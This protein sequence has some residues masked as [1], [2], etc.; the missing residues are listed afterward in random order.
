MKTSVKI[1]KTVNKKRLWKSLL[2]LS[3][4]A[5]SILPSFSQDLGSYDLKVDGDFQDSILANTPDW[6]GNP[7]YDSNRF[8]EEEIELEIRNWENKLQTTGIELRLSEPEIGNSNEKFLD[9]A[10]AYTAEG[11]NGEVSKYVE[12]ILRL[13]EQKTEIQSYAIVL[14]N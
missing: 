5:I 12:A 14:L 1:R 3:I 2:V 8:A 4:F 6:A 7:G 9:E 11:C 13:Q 10:E